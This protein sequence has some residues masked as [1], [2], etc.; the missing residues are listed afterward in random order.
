MCTIDSREA[1]LEQLA[2]RRPVMVLLELLSHRWALRVLWELREGPLTS[3]A[4]RAAC[5]EVSPGVLHTRLDELRAGGFVTRVERQGYALSDLGA[6]LLE[7]LLP[8]SAF[9]R[10]WPAHL[11]CPDAAT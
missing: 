1:I 4:L 5:D 6:E 10:D 2:Q 9:A 3:R 7:I 11:D 8:L